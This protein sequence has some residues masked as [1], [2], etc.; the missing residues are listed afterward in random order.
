ML[1][2]GHSKLLRVITIFMFNLI[3]TNYTSYDA[4]DY[5]LLLQIVCL[6]NG[7]VFKKQQEFITIQL[8]GVG[9]CDSIVKLDFIP[10]VFAPTPCNDFILFQNT[11][12]ES[13]SNKADRKFNNPYR[14]RQLILVGYTIKTYIH[15]GEYRS[16]ALL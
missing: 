10:R 13:S 2:K 7:F 12:K 11:L 8:L 6:F 9:D 15:N 3:T 16:Q 5:Y 1:Y 4:Y 14:F